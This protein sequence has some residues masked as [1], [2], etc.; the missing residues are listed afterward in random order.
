MQRMPK[1]AVKHTCQ[2]RAAL[3]GYLS[4]FIQQ[5]CRSWVKLPLGTIDAVLAT[6]LDYKFRM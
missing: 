1:E 4:A 5:G 2:T 3:L 6:H